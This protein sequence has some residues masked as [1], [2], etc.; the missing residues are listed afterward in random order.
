MIND[1]P[2]VLEPTFGTITAC[3]PAIPALWVEISAK[4]RSSIRGL[5]SRFRGSTSKLGTSTYAKG[6]YES[7]HSK[8]GYEMHSQSVARSHASSRN[9]THGN[10]MA[11]N[12][13]EH[14]PIVAHAFPSETYHNSQ[15]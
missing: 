5:L 14:L 2:S 13:I 4:A 10:G 6:G 3:L 11:M 9:E 8:S 12:D 15:K 1:I 7:H